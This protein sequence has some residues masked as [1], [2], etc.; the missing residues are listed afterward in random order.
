[1]LSNKYIKLRISLLGYTTQWQTKSDC[2]VCPVFSISD[3][4]H[5][6]SIVFNNSCRCHIRRKEAKLVVEIDSE[7]F[8]LSFSF[9]FSLLAQKL[10]LEMNRMSASN[11]TTTTKEVVIKRFYGYK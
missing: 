6:K 7:S 4:I 1:L 2:S 3:S 9:P 10:L 11:E 8:F 5:K